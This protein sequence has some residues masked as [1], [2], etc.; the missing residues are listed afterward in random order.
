MRLKSLNSGLQH[1][2]RYDKRANRGVPSPL[3]HKCPHIINLK[4]RKYFSPYHH[5]NGQLGTLIMR[6]DEFFLGCG[7]SFI[8]ISISLFVVICHN[9]L[10]NCQDMHF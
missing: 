3:L 8:K 4:Y 1:A 10:Q 9:T 5:Y 2:I 6:R 7:R